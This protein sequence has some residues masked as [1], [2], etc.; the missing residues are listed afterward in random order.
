MEL[1]DHILAHEISNEEAFRTQSYLDT[2]DNWTI[3]IGHLLGKDDKYANLTWNSNQ[4]MITFMQ[5]VN[6]SIRQI[7]R[8]ISVFDMLSPVRQRVLVDMMFNMG[9]NRFAGFVKTIAAIHALNYTEAYH[10]MLDSKW[11]KKDVPSRAARLS[12]RW[13]HG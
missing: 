11:A 1:Y 8:Q 4:V 3:G 9:P 10:E 12:Q 5:D 2:K 13:I 7:K 6:E